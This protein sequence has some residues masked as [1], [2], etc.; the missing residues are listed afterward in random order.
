MKRILPLVAL[1][2]LVLVAGCGGAATAASG[3]NPF[4]DA[5]T[6]SPPPNGSG[7]FVYVAI[8]ASDAIGFGAQCAD[9]QGYVPLLAQRMPAHTRLVN[10]G[11][12]G[13]TVAEALTDE[14]PDAVGARP[15]L[16]TVWLGPN[17]FREMLDGRLTLAAYSQQLDQL[18]ST[19]R[20]RTPARVFVANLPNLAQLPFFIHG[21]VPLPTI[22]R[23]TQ[24]W[25]AAIAAVAAKDGAV[26]VDLSQFDIASHP[27]YVFVD[28]FHPS[29]LGYAQ[30]AVIFWA[31]ISAHGGA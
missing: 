1:A 20:A 18:L 3:A 16:V 17:D 31:T 19:L 27:N 24:Q 8:G 9:T 12:G 6:C 7:P 21:T 28:G 5:A 25:N 11:I 22:A 14:L 10:L 26:L 15:A 2:A 30:L 4:G 29:T 13:A 23:D